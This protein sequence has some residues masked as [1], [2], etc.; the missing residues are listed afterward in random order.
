MKRQYDIYYSNKCQI[1]LSQKL[2]SPQAF[3][4]I[5]DILYIPGGGDHDRIALTDDL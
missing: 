2:A 4:N 3:K 5:K 1:Y